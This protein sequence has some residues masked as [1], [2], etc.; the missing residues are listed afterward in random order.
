M[1]LKDKE[2]VKS[3]SKSI[4]NQVRGAFSLLVLTLNTIF[5]S[6]LLFLVALVK[7]ALPIDSWRTSC[8]KLLNAIGQNWI[9]CNNLG[10]LLTKKIDWDVEGVEGLKPNTW[11]LVVANHQSWVDIAVLQKIFYR[12]I[13]MLKFFLKK[14][15]IWVPFLGAAWWALDFPFMRRTSSVNKDFETT[16]K[17]SE[18]FKLNPVSVMNFIEG[19]RFTP[20]KREKQDSPYKNLLKPKAGGIALVLGTLGEQLHSILDVTIVYPQGVPN[21]WEF[22]CTKSMAVK[23]R[24]RQLP[25]NGELMGDYLS[26]RE[27]RRQF[28]N[29]LNTLWTEKD[30]QMETLLQSCR[31]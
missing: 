30:K 1:S 19:T 18:K 22:L 11:Y 17:A 6:L 12:K 8:G 31:S 10:L 13:P 25:I 14:E 2:F 28:S 5:W 15:L 7:L 24:V 9:G 4:E 23:V 29:W 26:D 3:M 20:E 16:R 21:I 27:F